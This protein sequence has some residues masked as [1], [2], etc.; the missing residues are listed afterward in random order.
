MHNKTMREYTETKLDR[1]DKRPIA[2]NGCLLADSTTKDHNSTRWSNV[3]LYETDKQKVVV[4]IED[5]TCW[6]GERDFDRVD[7]FDTIEDAITHIEEHAARC[8]ES[9]VRELKKEHGIEVAER[10]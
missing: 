1:T 4:G 7:V 5:V 8:V 10:I 9:I 2:F 6:Q 3:K